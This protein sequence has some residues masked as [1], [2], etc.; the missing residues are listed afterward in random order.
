MPDFAKI[1]KKSVYTTII[2]LFLMVVLSLDK[3]N[4]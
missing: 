1:D 4:T 2:G 3:D